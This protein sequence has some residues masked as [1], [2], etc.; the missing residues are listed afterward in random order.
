MADKVKI[1]NID[2]S[3]HELASIDARDAVRRHPNEWST[4]PFPKEDPAA[5]QKAADEASDK[6]KADVDA[7]AK[8]D[9]EAAKAAQ[10][11]S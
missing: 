7:K 9:A 8:L 6:A 11:K 4:Q 5:Q 3:V 2:G 10:Q 1:H